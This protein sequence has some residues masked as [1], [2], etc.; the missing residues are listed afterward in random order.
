MSDKKRNLE[1]REEFP[2]GPFGSAIHKD[3]PVRSENIRGRTRHNETTDYDETQRKAY[4][5]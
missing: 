2:E 3:E 1:P 5:K 4:K